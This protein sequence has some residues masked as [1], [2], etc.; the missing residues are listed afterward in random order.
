MKDLI[1]NILF[2]TIPTLV[3][4]F[5]LMEVILSFFM[6][7]PSRPKAIYDEQTNLLR[8]SPESGTGTYTKGKF[9]QI[10]ADWS[11]NNKGWNYPVDYKDNPDKDL[12]A[13]MGDS[14][15]EALQVDADK[16]FPYLLREMIKDD[17]E[18]YAFG[19]SLYPLSQY[20]H[21]SRYVSER[22]NPSTLVFTVVHNDFNESIEGQVDDRRFQALMQ[23]IIESDSSITEREPYYHEYL[24]ERLNPGLFRRIVLKS[25]V[26][27][28]IR[29][30]NYLN[31]QPVNITIKFLK[32]LKTTELNQNPGFED[33]VN[34]E[35]V[36]EMKNQIEIAVYYVIKK[37]R[38]EN[39]HRRIIFM[40]D[41]PRFSIYAGTPVKNS[42][43]FWLHD[44][45]REA[46]E[47]NNVE[48]IDL[49]LLMENDYLQNHRRF[50][51]E[52]DSHWNEY[53]HQFVA[54]VLYSHLTD[55]S[56]WKP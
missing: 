44:L 36:L 45:M 23:L 43:N 15:V 19:K 53:G 50:N 46:T 34:T 21:L 16:K 41:A 3:I 38:E 17:Y 33:N 14:Y 25:R 9:F 29:Y 10:R 48:F 20:L 30:S 28:Y 4:L 6:P 37:I 7:L 39:P 47:E 2:I 1:K 18:V 31:I 24:Q 22:Y 27:R 51:T 8:F 52:I 26:Q 35:R 32:N 5:L 55:T 11:I 56:L 42:S 40:L 13:I 12:I 49:A 54:E